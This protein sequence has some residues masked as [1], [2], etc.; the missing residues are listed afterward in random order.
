[1]FLDFGSLHQKHRVGG[2]PGC[3]RR[4]GSD[5]WRPPAPPRGQYWGARSRTPSANHRFPGPPGPERR[6]G[7]TRDV[8][9]SLLACC[10]GSRIFRPCRLRVA[11]QASRTSHSRCFCKSRRRGVLF[12]VLS[13]PACLFLPS[14]F[15]RGLEPHALEEQTHRLSLRFQRSL[16]GTVS[17]PMIEVG[18]A[19][20]SRKIRRYLPL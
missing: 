10:R 12:H 2:P 3:V 19:R 6:D 1:M 16:E 8:A 15:P 13:W 14:A 5:G 18:R 17:F 4:D 9:A 11:A 20:G 7:S